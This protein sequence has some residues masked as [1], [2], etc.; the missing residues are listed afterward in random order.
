[1]TIVLKM[2][3]DF[4]FLQMCPFRKA[5][6]VQVSCAQHSLVN[7]QPRNTGLLQMYLPCL[8]HTAFYS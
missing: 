6:E 2:L 5:V 1:M 4:S 7:E 3:L 8:P